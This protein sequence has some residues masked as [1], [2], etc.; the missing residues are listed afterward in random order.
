ME[1]SQVH[2]DRTVP[3]KI[4]TIWPLNKGYIA[5]FSLHM[6]NTAIFLLPV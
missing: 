5:Y 2:N 4:S 1:N 3:I 6:C